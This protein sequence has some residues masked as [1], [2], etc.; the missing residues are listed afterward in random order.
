MREQDTLLLES[1][2]ILEDSVLTKL[3]KH[4]YPDL[5]LVDKYESWLAQLEGREP[6]NLEEQ[7]LALVGKDIYERLIKGYT[8]KQWSRP[9]SELPAF[10]IRRLPLRMVC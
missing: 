1:D 9:C 8:E 2:I 4:P 5:A 6:A 3:V 7:A 10:I